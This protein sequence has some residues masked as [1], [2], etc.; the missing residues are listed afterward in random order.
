MVPSI[1]LVDY[2]RLAVAIAPL[3]LL[4]RMVV[5][6]SRS[7]KLTHYPHELDLQG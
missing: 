5:K 6:N 3:G 2:A 7:F 4:A 1:A